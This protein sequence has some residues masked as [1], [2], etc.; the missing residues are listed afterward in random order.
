MNVGNL[1][2]LALSVGD[3]VEF[4]R[5]HDKQTKLT[6]TVTKIHA[7]PQDVVDVKSDAN[8]GNRSTTETV[9]AADVKVL[10]KAKETNGQKE[11]TQTQ[12]NDAPPSAP[13]SSAQP[14]GAVQAQDDHQAPAPQSNT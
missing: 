11:S 4:F 7:G 10:Q 8:N 1:L 3:V 14:V 9:H 2:K 12:A 13:Q 6:G 5:S